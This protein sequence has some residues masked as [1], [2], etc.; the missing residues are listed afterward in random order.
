[1]NK[2]CHRE[3]YYSIIKVLKGLNLMENEQV[4]NIFH[5]QVAESK[6]CSPVEKI[7]HRKEKR[8]FKEMY[9]KEANNQK[10]SL[11][12]KPVWRY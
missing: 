4:N 9:E 6:D 11:G 2:C 10:H 1:M 12:T 7:Y 8:R 5:Y 3:A